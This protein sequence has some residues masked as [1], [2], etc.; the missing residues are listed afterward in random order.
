MFVDKVKIKIKAGDGG[1]GAVSF[2]RDKFTI[3]GGPDGGDGGKGGD[4]VFVCTDKKNTLVDYYYK[5]KYFAENGE[6]GSKR[7]MDGKNGDSL[8]LE[9][10][11][12]TLVRN[13]LTNEILCDLKA[14]GAKYVALK[15]GKGGRGNCDKSCESH[16]NLTN[17]EANTIETNL[18]SML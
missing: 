16:E 7:N 3:K 6:S 17:Q 12:G 4:I 10:P 13:A 2:L 1:N 11:V 8:M 5:R 14:D 15:G 18:T 9:V